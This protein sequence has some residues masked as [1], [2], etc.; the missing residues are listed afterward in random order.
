MKS[1]GLISKIRKF[2]RNLGKISSSLIILAVAISLYNVFILH[3][4]GNVLSKKITAFEDEYKPAEITITRLLFEDCEDCYIIDQASD[5]I[6]NLD[7]GVI[8]ERDLQWDSQDAQTLISKYGISILPTIV[9][10]GETDKKNV[11]SSLKKIG[12][13]KDDGAV[14]F[15]KQVL[16]FYDVGRE[17][18]LGQ[19]SITSIVDSSC[20]HCFDMGIVMDAFRRAGVTITSQEELEY[21]T[22]EADGLIEKYGVQ[23]IPAL[24]I[25]SDIRDYDAV[26]EIWD[27]LGA[28]EKK[29]SYVL[30]TNTSPYLDLAT[31][32][33]AGLVRLVYLVDSSCSDCY[34]VSM[35]ETILGRFGV[36][37]LNTTTYDINSTDGKALVDAYNI[38]KVPTA[39]L[40]PET[41]MY[42]GLIQAWPQVGSIENDGWYVFR[43]LSALGEGI[44]FKDI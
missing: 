22:A 24:I 25:S 41:S 29:G 18:V 31:G 23:H 15:N 38:T 14:I 12:E 40:S 26:N 37:I 2:D 1:K 35:H 42:V 6:K 30:H 43:E 16:P 7:V 20:T 3:D 33:V 4:T 13:M 11:E 21:D 9:I 44:V 27:Q 8:E 5:Q 10:T 32:E 39:L 17:A 34:D 36:A 19:V 28:V